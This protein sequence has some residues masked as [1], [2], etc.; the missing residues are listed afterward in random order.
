M[1]SSSNA[2]NLPQSQ[3]SSNSN[4]PIGTI[5]NPTPVSQPINTNSSI[6]AYRIQ[7]SVSNTTNNHNNNV[8]NQNNPQLNQHQITNNPISIAPPSTMYHGV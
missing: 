2:S 8:N 1:N 6:P 4:I 7:P 3:P 5:P